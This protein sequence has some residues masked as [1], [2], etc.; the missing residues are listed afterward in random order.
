MHLLYQS[1]SWS[2]PNNQSR[3]ASWFNAL[4]HLNNP[5]E[6]DTE[7]VSNTLFD[8]YALVE[9]RALS[10]PIKMPPMRPKKGRFINGVWHCNC[11]PRLPASH[12]QVR[13]DSANKGRWFY[14]C[15]NPKETQCGFFLWDEDAKLREEETLLGNTRTEMEMMDVTPRAPETPRNERMGNA[16]GWLD[17]DP[18]TPVGIHRTTAY[19]TP[20]ESRVMRDKSSQITPLLERSSPTYKCDPLSGDDFDTQKPRRD[21]LMLADITARKRKQDFDVESEPSKAQRLGSPP[22][23]RRRFTTKDL[24]KREASF[25]RYTTPSTVRRLDFGTPITSKA[26][27][28]PANAQPSYLP[29]TPTTSRISSLPDENGNY[30]ITSSV[31]SIL[32]SASMTS[33]TRQNVQQTL[34]SYA[35]RVSGIERGRDITRVALKKKDEKMVELEQKIQQLEQETELDKM[36]ISHFKKDMAESVAARRGKGGI[37]GGRA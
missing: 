30:D 19:P 31:L 26:A 12:F 34:N 28:V 2:T 5:T 11:D 6:N 24:A 20:G 7:Q 10:L 13:K 33:A 37:R 25:G 15:T 16:G 32:Q 29:T 18:Q 35:L 1:I 23:S 27:A 8:K 22:L 3:R 21:G 4:Q 17:E 14:C 36:I 9:D